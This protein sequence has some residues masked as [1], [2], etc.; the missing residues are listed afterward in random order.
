MVSKMSVIATPCRFAFTRS[1][2]A[3]SCGTLIWKLENVWY[4]LITPDCR[5][6]F[7][8]AWVAA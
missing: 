7:I 4:G 8:S 5:A 6:W 3:Y 2:S 1:T